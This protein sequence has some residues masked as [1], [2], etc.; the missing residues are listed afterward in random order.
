MANILDVA[1]YFL[2]KVDRDAG[3]E[4]THLKL[5]KLCYY[6]QAWHLAIE[7]VPLCDTEFQAWVH[8]PVSPHLWDQYRDY[9]YH[10]ID[11]PKD[12]DP[13]VLTEEERSFLDEV[14][15]VYGKYTA[16][17]LEN[18]THVEE[19]WLEARKGYPPNVHCTRPISEETMKRYY[20]SLMD[21]G[22]AN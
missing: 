7:G 5:Q 15:D 10:P 8:G 11:P 12:F 3:D 22:E 18:L 4:I 17:Y 21:N 2:V 6:A 9:K 20:R 13:N 1:K 14:W 19:P 16:K